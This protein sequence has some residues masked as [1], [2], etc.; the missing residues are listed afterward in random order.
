MHNILQADLSCSIQIILNMIMQQICFFGKRNTIKYFR[1]II[2]LP[3]LKESNNLSI[4]FQN[5]LI[6]FHTK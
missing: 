4:L 5:S 1:R 2:N 6:N 3:S